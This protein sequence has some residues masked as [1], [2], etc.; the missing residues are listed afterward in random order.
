MIFNL[1][2]Y[3]F[4]TFI[5]KKATDKRAEAFS[6]PDSYLLFDTFCLDDEFRAAVHSF[7]DSGEGFIVLSKL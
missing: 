4:R 7:F 1:G 3:F 2:I 6:C 5:K